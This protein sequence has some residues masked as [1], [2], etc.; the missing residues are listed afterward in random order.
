MDIGKTSRNKDLLINFLTGLTSRYAFTSHVGVRSTAQK[1]SDELF[2]NCLISV[3]VRD[4]NAFIKDIHIFVRV[5]HIWEN[6]LILSRTLFT[7]L[8]S[9]L[10]LISFASF[11]LIILIF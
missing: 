10:L 8:K 11:D 3:S 5:Y 7:T 2:S 9:V 6:S 4:S 1:V